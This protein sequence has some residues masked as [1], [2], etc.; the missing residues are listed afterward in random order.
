M[1]DRYGRKIEYMRVSVT[2]RCNLRCI[3][4]MP[5]E[6]VQSIAHSQ[7]LTFDEIE[8]ICRI[9]AGL[10][11]SKIKL[12][13]GEPLARKNLPELLG[14][15]KRLKGIEQVTLTTN[16]IFLKDNID[17]L[18]SCGMDGVNISIDT[19]NEEKYCELTRGGRL[20]SALEG[21]EAALA[22]PELH[23][24]VN[25]VPMDRTDESDW[26]GLA[27]LARD[28]RAEVRFIEMMPVGLGKQFRGRSSD[29]VLE[30]LERAFGRAE[31]Y[32]GQLGNGPASYVRFPGFRARIGFIS[33][34][35]HQ[36]CDSCNRIRLTST[37]VL[38]PCLQYGGG[39]DI[40]GLMRSGAEDAQIKTAMRR[41]IYRK[42]ARHHFAD[43]E[44]M[45]EEEKQ[46]LEKSEMSRI[47]G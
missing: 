29:E 33:A 40:R 28:G 8:R 17:E 10:G 47:G 38:K 22:F 2:D 30:V 27:E 31:D 14:M 16:G 19:L 41:A 3:Y 39:T 44:A 23:V 15:I 20:S 12:T 9:G 4:C 7:I 6:G 18:V 25:C 34:V 13:G 37:G 36:F 26:I 35:S 1:Q 5:P 42:P 32:S 43:G 24:K 21:L 11:I 45:T 46:S